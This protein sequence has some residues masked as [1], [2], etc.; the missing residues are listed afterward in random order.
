MRYLAGAA[1]FVGLIFA[2]CST[3]TKGD[4]TCKYYVNGQRRCVDKAT[5]PNVVFVD[6]QNDGN[7]CDYAI[8]GSR[9]FDLHRK[10]ED[11]YDEID[12]K[13]FLSDCKALFDEF[14]GKM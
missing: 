9:T 5:Q 4:I 3:V 12:R 11:R 6:M 10:K 7:I 14:D 2:G 1:A 8:A 13:M